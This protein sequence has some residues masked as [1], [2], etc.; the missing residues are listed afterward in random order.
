MSENPMIFQTS[1][2][3]LEFAI[4]GQGLPILVLH[5]TAGGFDQGLALG[6]L[7]EDAQIVAISRAGYLGTPLETGRDPVQLADACCELLDHLHLERIGVFGLSAGAMAAISFVLHHPQRSLGLVLGSP[8][9]E[10]PPARSIRQVS[11]FASLPDPVIWALICLVKALVLPVAF[12]D[13]SV[14]SLAAAFFDVYPLARRRAGILNDG[15]QALCFQQPDYARIDLPTLIFHGAADPLVPV[16]SVRIASR[17]ISGAEYLEI[18]AGGHQ[19]VVT[20]FHRI[21]RVLLRWIRQ[22]STAPSR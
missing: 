7:F 18:P 2:G 22:I 6:S 4:R 12:R 16:E 14:R 17:A 1:A 8:I 19:C 11:M 10:P 21:Q 5:S 9:L 20:D 15:Q 3:P 13:P